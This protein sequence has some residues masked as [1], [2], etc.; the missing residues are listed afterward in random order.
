MLK[1]LN[2]D[3]LK[4]YI[5]RIG[6]YLYYFNG[7][8]TYLNTNMVYNIR[9]ISLKY[10]KIT[11][12]EIDW[13]NQK[14]FDPFT[15]D[16]FMNMV[17]VYFQ[18]KEEYIEV[19]PNENKINE[20]FLK[21]AKLYNKKIDIL[22]KGVG[23][24]IIFNKNANIYPQ[25]I[26][27][28]SNQQELRI[29]KT[30]KYLYN[31]K[32]KFENETDKQNDIY[33]TL[34][35][36][37]IE[38][39]KYFKENP[40]NINDKIQLLKSI[41]QEKAQ[42]EI[43][44]TFKSKKMPKLDLICNKN[45]NL[46]NKLYIDSPENSN[47]SNPGF[48]PLNNSKKD[49]PNK[50]NFIQNSDPNFKDFKEKITNKII[51]SNINESSDHFKDYSY[52]EINYPNENSDI[53]YKHYIMKSDSL[54]EKLFNDNSTT[55]NEGIISNGNGGNQK[56]NYMKFVRSFF[57]NNNKNINNRLFKIPEKSIEKI[58]IPK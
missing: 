3:Q 35:P 12:L 15:P 17:F 43:N 8:R 46:E 30:R 2:P 34:P 23:S 42:S 55:I 38:K 27:G 14:K 24:K 53:K 33:N 6:P 40:I 26:T 57:E 32:I 4:N 48:E 54:N 47:R 39:I 7:K 51:K 18:G 9:S 50:I 22:S 28:L 25:T 58:Q 29:I 16:S 37:Y 45:P 5:W 49:F 31:R 52:S 13:E 19:E 11:V 10:K 20:L 56:S 21:C 44:L 36:R 41:K 1:K